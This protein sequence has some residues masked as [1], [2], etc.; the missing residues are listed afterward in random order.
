M[1]TPLLFVLIF[2]ELSDIVLALDALPAALS[3]TTD[4]VTITAA[5]P[6]ALLGLRSLYS[7][8]ANVA[9]RLTFLKLAV[10]VILAWIAVTLVLEHVWGGLPAVDIALARGHPHRPSHRHLPIAADAPPADRRTRLSLKDACLTSG[11]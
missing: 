9:D 10:A 7:L 3:V 11:D 1:E 6:F 2:V 4:P 8:L 5:H